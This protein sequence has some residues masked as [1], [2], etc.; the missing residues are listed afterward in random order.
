MKNKIIITISI[1]LIITILVFA[2]FALSKVINKPTVQKPPTFQQQY[3][4]TSTEVYQSLPED[5][6]EFFVNFNNSLHLFDD[7]DDNGIINGDENIDIFGNPSEGTLF[8]SVREYCK[9]YA[10]RK[11][12]QIIAF[13]S[14]EVT[15]TERDYILGL[16]E[17]YKNELVSKGAIDLTVHVDMD[18]YSYEETSSDRWWTI[19]FPNNYGDI[20]S[21]YVLMSIHDNHSG[22]PDVLIMSSE[23]EGDPSE[24][25]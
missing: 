14:R 22:E 23:D 25:D 7:D 21:N 6:K 15:K 16:V 10:E 11:Q 1:I 20:K 24:E 4:Y 12:Q 13:E 19:R 3:D 9:V 18:H 17:K 2:Y 8:D 5:E